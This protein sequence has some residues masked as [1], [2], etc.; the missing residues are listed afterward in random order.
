MKNQRIA[1]LYFL[2]LLTTPLTCYSGLFGPSNYEECVLENM[3]GVVSDQ[4]ARQIAHA[5]YEKFSKYEPQ[6]RTEVVQPQKIDEPHH[7]GFS[8]IGQSR[9][10]LNNLIANLNITSSVIEQTGTKYGQYKSHDYGHVL[11]L[12]ITNR[13]SF[14]I[15]YIKIGLPKKASKSY[16]W[17]DASDYSE[18]YECPAPIEP[19]QSFVVNCDVPNIERRKTGVV[20]LGFKIWA[21]EK[22]VTDFMQRNAIPA[23]Q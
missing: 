6:P 3:K 16:S 13:N 12:T 4:A 10:S 21:T 5:C 20:I 9:P 2:C 15:S 1:K 11:K 23:R 22:E 18:F 17:D 8:S 14:A 19:M 7:Y